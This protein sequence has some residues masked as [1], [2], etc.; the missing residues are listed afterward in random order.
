[1]AAGRALFVS[2]APLFL[3]GTKGM[4]QMGHFP[5]G[6]WERTEGCMVQV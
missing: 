6:S 4:E 1:M 5:S 3:T 2:D